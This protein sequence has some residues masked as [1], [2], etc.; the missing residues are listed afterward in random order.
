V[1]LARLPL[2]TLVAMMMDYMLPKRVMS[3][4]EAWEI[5]FEQNGGALFKDLARY[6]I[7]MPR[8]WETT[9]KEKDHISH[10]AWSTF[11][12]YAAAAFHT[13]CPRTRRWTGCRP[14]TRTPS[15]STTARATTGAERRSRASAS[16]TDAAHAVPDLPDPAAVHR[17]GRPDHPLPP[18]GALQGREVPLL[19][20]RLPRHLRREPEKYVQAWLPV[21]QIYQG[22]CFRPEA[23]PTAPDFNPVAEAL[24]Y[25]ASGRA[26]MAATSP[27]MPTPSAGR[28]GRA[29]RPACTRWTR[30]GSADTPQ[31]QSA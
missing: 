10:Q 31:R 12:Q 29:G 15:T 14:S 18:R 4:K 7:R 3:W 27:P 25:W 30:R 8:H 28:P 9:V 26:W 20:G 17:A 22:N 6:G 24:S 21:H 23:D 1:V 16:T 19:L 2:L 11:Y 13:G 5:Y